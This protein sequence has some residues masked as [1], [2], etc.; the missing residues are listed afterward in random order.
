MDWWIWSIIGFGC[1][2]I[3]A[4]M[5][6]IWDLSNTKKNVITI[7]LCIIVLIFIQGNPLMLISKPKYTGNTQVDA[8]LFKARAL[9]YDDIYKAADEMTEIYLKR[10]LSMYDVQETVEAAA[11]L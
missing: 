4:V 10:G 11:N 3:G 9:K 8:V 1:S 6:K 2:L 7:T 5:Q